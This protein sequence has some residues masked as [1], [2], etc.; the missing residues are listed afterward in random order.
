MRVAITGATGLVGTALSTFLRKGGHTVVPISRRPIAG[1]VQWDPAVG[2]LDGEPLNGLDAV[3]HLAGENIAAERWSDA[4]KAELRDSRVIPTQ[5]LA[6]T[7]ASLDRKPGVLISASAV[8]IYGD[9]ADR[10]VTESTPA[11]DGFLAELA[12]AWEAAAEPARSVGIRTV[13]PRFATV[14]AANGG[15]LER[16]LPRSASASAGRL[17]AANNGCT[18]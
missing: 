2:R 6:R 9:Q 17:P 7:L 3:V 10:V 18:G 8:G 16:M 5:L 14:L 4:R 11:G 1:G 12:T 13:H 15:A